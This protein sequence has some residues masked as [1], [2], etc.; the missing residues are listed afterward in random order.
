G[1]FGRLLIES[2]A[3]PVVGPK[4]LESIQQFGEGSRW[5]PET[6]DFVGRVFMAMGTAETGSETYNRQLVELMD[7]LREAFAGENHLIVVEEGAI[8]NERAWARRFPGAARF[9][10]GQPEAGE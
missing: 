7:E 5:T 8:H 10:F 4:F 2:P 6:D 9:L 1:V 3:V